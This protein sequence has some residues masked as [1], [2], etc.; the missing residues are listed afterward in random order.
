MGTVFETGF[1]EHLWDVYE[2]WIGLEQYDESNPV[3]QEFLDRFEA[4]YG[5]RPEYYSPLLWR[6]C[7]MSLLYAF[8]DAAPLSPLGVKDALER[9]KML[10]AASGSPGLHHLRSVHAPRLGGRGRHGRPE[11]GPRRQGA[12]QVLEVVVGGS[13]RRGVTVTQE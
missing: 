7:A 13:L 11:V 2:G 9:V 8:A 6:D 10:P 12:R 3:G 1:N 4:E 5:H